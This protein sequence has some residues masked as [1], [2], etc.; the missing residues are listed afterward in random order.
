M[1]QL[2]EGIAIGPPG[3]GITFVNQ[4]MAD[5]LGYP[6][7][8]I[9]GKTGL[10]FMDEEEKIKVSQ[11]RKNLKEGK[12]LQLEY[13]FRRKDG[14]ILWTLGNS[15]PL[16]D[17]SGRHIGNLGMHSDITERKKAED[18][19]RISE[20]RLSIVLKNSSIVVSQLDKD[21]RYTWIYNFHPDYQPERILGKQTDEIET[22]PNRAELKKIQRRVLES[23]IGTKVELPINIAGEPEIYN[24]SIE[25]LR[26]SS[27]NIVG[28]TSVSMNVT[29][30]K[31][32]EQE[33]KK[34]AK[35]PEENPSPIFRVS[36]DGVILYV[37]KAGLS[38]T[39]S[40]GY[41]EGDTLSGLWGEFVIDTLNSGKKKVVDSD[42]IDGRVYSATI[43]PIIDAGYVNVYMTDVT[44]RKQMEDALRQSQADLNRAQSVGN[45]GSWRL[46]VQTNELVWSDETHQIFGIPK[47]NP[48]TYEA[49]LSVIHPDDRKYVSEKWQA[50]T[51]G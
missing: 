1:R 39:S 6:K 45:I 42:E 16:Y 20:E 27:G 47:G 31:K 51:T 10:D 22:D 49:F 37:N 21:L 30:L 8:E 24:V 14:S 15:S 4:R 7:E 18:A 17:N 44:E 46:N 32:A 36:K 40:L 11:V 50:A 43:A 48:M 23:G 9:I 29:E 35:F 12:S 26:D 13:K 38:L 2:Q 28:L 25:P 41:K 3:G 34:L 33:I 19:L 5:M